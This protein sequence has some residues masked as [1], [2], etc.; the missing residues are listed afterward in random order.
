MGVYRLSS[1]GMQDTT[2]GNKNAGNVMRKN[3][4]SEHSMPNENAAQDTVAYTLRQR[5]GNLFMNQNLSMLEG[6]D[7]HK[8]TTDK[9]G[10]YRVG[11]S[12]GLE[13]PRHVR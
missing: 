4:P 3:T 8:T 1:S 2:A 6:Q 7:G 11:E 13:G 5:V 9:Y 12:M 10:L